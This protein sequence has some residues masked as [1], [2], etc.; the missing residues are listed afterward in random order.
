MEDSIDDSQFVNIS[1]NASSYD[2]WMEIPAARH[3]AGA[4]MSFVDG[5]VERHKWV[6]PSTHI[7]V[8]RSVIRFLTPLPGASKDVRWLTEHATSL[9]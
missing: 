1:R 8:K 5:R 7:P 4:C 9:P 6:E 3:S 2:K